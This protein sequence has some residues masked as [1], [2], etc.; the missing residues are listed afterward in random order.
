VSEVYE[1]GGRRLG[2]RWSQRGLDA[3]LRALAGAARGVQD[4]PPNLSIVVGES[5]GR[6]R[7]KHQLHVQ[8]RLLNVIRSDGGLVRAIAR[9][10]ATL[11]VEPPPGTLPLNALLLIGPDGT[12]VAVDSHLSM[13]VRPLGARLRRQGLRIAH[14]PRLDFDPDRSVAVL[15]DP[16][17]ALGVSKLALA[18]RW[19]IGPEDDDLVAGEVRIV[20]FVYVGRPEPESRADSV[21]D[22]LLMLRDPT[23]R[24][25]RGKVARL[26]ALTEGLELRG[27]FVGDRRRLAALL[28]V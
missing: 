6:T 13:D 26:A 16:A 10:L 11:A 8:S 5:A 23:G 15:G 28:G 9:A 21:A 24:L 14:P 7:A 12:A 25:D 1:V 20:R 2:V 4:A 22:M 3:E 19:P 18:A 27:V 17:A